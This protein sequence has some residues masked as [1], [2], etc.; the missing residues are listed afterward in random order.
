MGKLAGQRVTFRASARMGAIAASLAA[1]AA[2]VIPSTALASDAQIGF[3]PGSAQTFLCPSGTDF[4]QSMSTVASYS[5]PSGGTSITQWSLQAG[6][7]DTG[8]AALEVWRLTTTPM[9]YEL[10]GMSAP[11]TVTPGALINGDLSSSPILVNP[12]DLL[13][14]HTEGLVSCAFITGTGSADFVAFGYGPTPGATG[15]E[16]LDQPGIGLAL[17]VTATVNVTTPPNPVPK[18]ANQCKGGGWQK[19]TDTNGTPFKNQ[20]DCVSF[21]ATDG[22]NLAG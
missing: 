11:E 16:T 3:L 1:A 14:L 21:V 12:G 8:S 6:P 18:T 9:V 4:V 22:A 10:V 19:L 2:L 20:G 7:G 15:T 13:G 17:N 5:V